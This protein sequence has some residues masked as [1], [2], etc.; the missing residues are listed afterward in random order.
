VSDGR[1]NDGKSAGL[2]A[3]QCGAYLKSKGCTLG[4]PLDGGGSSTIYF[5]GKVLNAA[6]NGQRAV[7]D[8][9][10]FK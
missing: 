10:M 5:N 9:V 4:V 1:K 2:N 6:K 8:F 7:T 3:Y